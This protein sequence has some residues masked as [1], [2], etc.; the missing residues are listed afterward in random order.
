[1]LKN[2]SADI[3]ELDQETKGLPAPPAQLLYKTQREG[4]RDFRPESVNGA[5]PWQSLAKVTSAPLDTWDLHVGDVVAVH[6]DQ[7]MEEYAKV[8]DLRRLEDGRFVVVYTWFYTR[9]NIES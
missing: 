6:L 3:A 9:Q 8:S 1:M 2:T 7:G 5:K 4:V